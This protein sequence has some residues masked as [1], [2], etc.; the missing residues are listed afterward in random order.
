MMA[1]CGS[2]NAVL[3]L[4]AIANEA[5]LDMNVVGSDQWRDIIERYVANITELPITGRTLMVYVSFDQS[6]FVHTHHITVVE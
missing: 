1:I 3:H 4:A 6:L 2:T 5:D